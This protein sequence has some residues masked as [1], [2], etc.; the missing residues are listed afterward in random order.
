MWGRKKQ[1][2]TKKQRVLPRSHSW[3]GWLPRLVLNCRRKIQNPNHLLSPGTS[4]SD[5]FR[6]SKNDTASQLS[7]RASSPHLND[8]WANNHTTMLADHPLWCSKQKIS[9]DRLHWITRRGIKKKKNLP[10]TNSLC[11]Q[12]LSPYWEAKVIC[13]K[14]ISSMKP[15][16]VRY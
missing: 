14:V 4:P 2:K 9:N 10:P 5:L 12:L 16:K 13:W 15:N 7:S 1:N 3:P 8:I 6:Q 11:P